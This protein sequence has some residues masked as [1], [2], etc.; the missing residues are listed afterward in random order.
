RD[1]DTG[2]RANRLGVGVPMGGADRRIQRGNRRLAAA[3]FRQS[4]G[5]FLAHAG[6]GGSWRAA[7][8]AVSICALRLQY[9]RG[10]RFSAARRIDRDR[11]KAGTLA[12]VRCFSAR[13]LGV[14]VG[15]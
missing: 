6:A 12:L 10:P 14:G 13:V 7:A 11:C 4:L 2:L 1:A 15:L 3:A 8:A 5:L 9:A